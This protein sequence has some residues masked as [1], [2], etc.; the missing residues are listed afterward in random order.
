MVSFSNG[1]PNLPPRSLSALFTFP[2][3]PSEH[4]ILFAPSVCIPEKQHGVPEDSST[5]QS[6]GSRRDQGGSVWL[7]PS[8][9]HTRAAFSQR[10]LAAGQD[11]HFLSFC[12]I[13]SWRSI[14][15][16]RAAHFSVHF[17]SF[18]HFEISPP[19]PSKRIAAMHLA[20]SPAWIRDS[21]N[22]VL[23]MSV[24]LFFSS[25]LCLGTSHSF[26]LSVMGY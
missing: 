22:F 25:P 10:R 19:A 8:S 4:Q 23:D 7:G 3:L 18:D 11:T 13:L 21:I 6:A 26:L 12:V 16:Y 2:K 1:H 14:P 17:S 9:G 5:C 20:S 15:V 24:G